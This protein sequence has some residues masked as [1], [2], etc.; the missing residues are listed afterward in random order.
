MYR[1]VP[2][3]ARKFTPRVNPELRATLTDI[4]DGSGLKIVD[5]RSQEEYH[6]DTDVDEKPGHIPGAVNVVWQ[7]LVGQDG[8]LVCSYEKAKQIIDAANINKN[9]RVVTYCKVGARAAVGYL[10]FQRLGYDVRLYD[11][12]YAEWEKSDQPVER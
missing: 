12:S 1:P 8:N 10:A 9:D 4:K 6:G 7:E 11:A 3:Q 2:R 5:T